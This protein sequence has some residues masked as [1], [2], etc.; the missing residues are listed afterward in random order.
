LGRQS[1]ITSYLDPQR[2]PPAP[3]QGAIGLEIRDAD[4][5][6]RNLIKPLDHI[7]TVIAVTAERALL[8]ALDGSCRTAIGAF[9]RVAGDQL[10]LKGEILSP[11]GGISIDGTLSGPS[12]NPAA[13]GHELGQILRDKAGSEF[14]KLFPA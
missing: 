10:T 8:H 13:L 2:F 6:T 7:P 5:R 9:S 12:A 14:F 4:S 3:A 11:D 1:E